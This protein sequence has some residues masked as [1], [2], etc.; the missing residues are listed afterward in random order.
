MHADWLSSSSSVSSEM[1]LTRG[2]RRDW[3]AGWFAILAAE[4]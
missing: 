2:K 3:Q 1:P 4:G